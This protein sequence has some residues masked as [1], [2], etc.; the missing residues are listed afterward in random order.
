MSRPCKIEDTDEILD[1]LK[2][3]LGEGVIPRTREYWHWKHYQNPFGASPG[4]VAEAN[5]KIVGVRL[6][7]RWNWRKDGKIVPAVRAVDTAT[8]PDWQ[9][10][11]IFSGL[12]TKLLDQI[13]REGVVFVYNTPNAQS[14]AGYLKMGWRIVGRVPLLVRPIR[15]AS[16]LFRPFR[17][18]LASKNW[19][20]LP[21]AGVFFEQPEFETFVHQL[22]ETED[23][24]HT[25]RTP[26]YFRWRYRDIPGFEYRALWKWSAS[27]GAA[28][29][30]RRRLRRKFWELS[31]SDIL[32]SRG[33]DSDKICRDLVRDVL[34]NANCDYAVV[35]AAKG[36]QTESILKKSGFFRANALGPVFVIK[37][38]G[39]R[40]DQTGL[41][42]WDNWGCAIAD[43]EIF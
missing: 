24:Y 5:G 43:L 36:T 25:P 20:S 11:G 31:L 42:N 13:Q 4:L 22:A 29:L 23:R 30:F 18:D 33:V 38:I 17:G 6:F 37:E 3:A 21:R 10:K 40:A 15:L 16:L 7:M 8:H 1:L 26:D 19:E 28:L 12:T 39:D 14:K 41:M 32:V 27:G 35:T 9:R 34:K 2:I